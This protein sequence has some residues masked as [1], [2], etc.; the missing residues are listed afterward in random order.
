[1]TYEDAGLDGTFSTEESWE[2]PGAADTYPRY[3]QVRFKGSSFLLLR[4]LF[5]A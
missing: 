2:Q 1:M 4:A 3:K 5:Q